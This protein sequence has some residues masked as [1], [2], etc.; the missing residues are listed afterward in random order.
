MRIGTRAVRPGVHPDRNQSRNVGV[1]LRER[2]SRP[3][4]RNS[5]EAKSSQDLMIAIE[6][7]RHKKIEIL[8][9]Q[10]ES[11][12]H[13]A[14]N[15][16]GLRIYLDAAANH[17]AV[18]A[19]APL[20]VAVAQHHRLGSMRI[21]IS[22]RKP[23]AHGRRNVES[24][25]H[26]V[27]DQSRVNLLRPR[28]ACHVRSAASPYAQRLKRPVLLCKREIHRRRKAETTGEI[29]KSCGPRSVDPHGHKL[30]GIRIGKRL[31][32]HTV[33]HAEDRR[34][35]ADSYRQRQKHSHGKSRR[36]FQPAEGELD[37]GQNRFDHGPLPRFAAA[38]LNDSYVA[39]FPARRLLGSSMRHSLL[40]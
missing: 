28:K 30:I 31:Q 3:K 2:D 39:K 22:V 5:V 16:P 21:L 1:G 38:F 27:T 37:V 12:R 17:A 23:A 26:T 19:E 9:D 14:D 13:H 32:Q 24:L 35:C 11:S 29:C 4:P 18:T 33:D 25:Q 40:D 10:P 34:V 20:P 6:G 15:L 7:E 36:A 8:I